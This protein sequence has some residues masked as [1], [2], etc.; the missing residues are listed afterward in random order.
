MKKIETDTAKVEDLCEN[1]EKDI[2]EYNTNISTLFDLLKN[3][4]NNKT[5]VGNDALNYTDY[6][7]PFEE[8]YN[9]FGNDLTDF[10]NILKGSNSDL[11]NKANDTRVDGGEKK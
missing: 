1:I 7:V 4:V 3:F 8:D 6:A 9:K 10:L 5:W 2:N 11:Q